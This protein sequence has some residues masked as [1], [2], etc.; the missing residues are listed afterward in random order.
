MKKLCI[1]LLKQV[2]DIHFGMMRSEVRAVLGDATEFNKT[3]LSS[4]PTDDYGYCHIFYDENDKC[5]AIEVFDVAEVYINDKQIFPVD[6]NSALSLL[7]NF[8]EDIS[9]DD[10]GFISCKYA[11]G[12]Y[13]PDETMESILIGRENYYA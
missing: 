11:I 7:K 12:I 6:K 9:Q 8:F 2:N 10:D 5:E 13:A 4:T 3:A 1:V